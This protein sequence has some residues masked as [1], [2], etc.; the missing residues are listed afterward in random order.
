MDYEL[1][2]TRVKWGRDSI[3]EVI[4]YMWE[5]MGTFKSLKV[6][7]DTEELRSKVV[8][9]SR[10]KFMKHRQMLRTLGL[11]WKTKM[12]HYKLLSCNGTM[13]RIVSCK[14]F[15][16]TLDALFYVRQPLPALL[17]FYPKSAGVYLRNGKRTFHMNSFLLFSLL[18]AVLTIVLCPLER[19]WYMEVCAR[20][21][22][23]LVSLQ[24][25]WVQVS[26][27]VDYNIN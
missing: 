22:L 27:T 18:V 12:V 16:P 7:G 13:K 4:R 1:W 24:R 5:T 2:L 15:F 6:M 14:Y 17:L 25:C 23:P 19:S 9:R 3:N 21:A 10:E 20:L 8:K 26:A 11:I